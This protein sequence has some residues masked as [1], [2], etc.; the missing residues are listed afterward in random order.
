[1]EYLKKTTNQPTKQKA[2]K[3]LKFL[4]HARYQRSNIL[5]ASDYMGNKIHTKEYHGKARTGSS[6]KF[7][8]SGNGKCIVQGLAMLRQS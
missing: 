8:I 7:L 4:H 2:P 6:Q 3:Q 5:K 1:M